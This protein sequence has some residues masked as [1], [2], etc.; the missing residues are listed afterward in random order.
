MKLLT[1]KNLKH[2]YKPDQI[3]CV[4]SLNKTHFTFKP[5]KSVTNN[6]LINEYYLNK[7]SKN[8]ELLYYLIPKLL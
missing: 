1:T 2:F 4:V 3:E 5:L 8:D 7:V 6:F